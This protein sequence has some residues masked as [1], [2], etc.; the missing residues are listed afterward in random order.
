[1]GFIYSPFPLPTWKK[2]ACITSNKKRRKLMMRKYQ[3]KKYD[4]NSVLLCNYNRVKNQYINRGIRQLWHQS[5]SLRS[6]Y[7]QSLPPNFVI[8][9]LL[10]SLFKLFT[11]VWKI[12]L[13]VQVTSD[14]F[15]PPLKHCAHTPPH[16]FPLFNGYNSQLLLDVFKII[17]IL[18]SFFV[19]PWKLGEWL[20]K[21]NPREN[22]YN[23][24]S[25]E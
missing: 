21:C 20:E 7:W 4:T 1:M 6:P 18:H 17:H 10:L 14:Q 22:K 24:V 19:Y 16:Y 9:F 2:C 11:K 15:Q 8:S 12:L 13:L 3:I 5:Y 23:F 25:L